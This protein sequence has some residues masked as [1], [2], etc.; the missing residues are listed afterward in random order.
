MGSSGLLPREREPLLPPVGRFGVVCAGCAVERVWESEISRTPLGLK[1]WVSR[2]CLGLTTYRLL[3]I[4]GIATWSDSCKTSD[5]LT[6]LELV[7]RRIKHSRLPGAVNLLAMLSDPVS[8]RERI[9]EC[10]LWVHVKRTRISYR[11]CR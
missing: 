5:V 4:T 9:A 6:S 7:F 2:N 8:E 10:R 3:K 1:C 11:T